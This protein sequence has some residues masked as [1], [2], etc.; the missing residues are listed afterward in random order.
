MRDFSKYDSAFCANIPIHII[1]AVQ[2]YGVLLVVDKKNGDIVQLSENADQLFLMPARKMA[3]RLFS[4]F[5]SLA[6]VPANWISE[7]GRYNIVLDIGAQEHDAILHVD[8][9]QLTI[10]IELASI[11]P[12][13]QNAIDFFREIKAPMEQIEKAETL[14]ALCTIAADVLKR[15]S[16][17]DKVMIYSFD[18]DWNGFVLAEAREPDMESYLGFTFPAADIPKPARDLYLRNAYRCIPDREAPSV[19]LYP[20]VHPLTETFLDM[21]LC[22]LRAVPTV[23]LEYLKNM[24]VGASMSVRLLRHGELWG[25]IACHHKTA[26]ASNG[27]QKALFELFSGVIS[28]RITELENQQLH[29][30]HSRLASLYA[31]LIDGVNQ[32]TSM[33]DALLYG[34]PNVLELFNADGA[35]AVHHQQS[36]SV[37]TAPE[38]ELLKDLLLW[39]HVKQLRKIYQTDVLPSVYEMNEDQ[40][41]LISGLLAIPIR[42]SEDEYLLLFR[43]EVKRTTNW[44][45]NPA[46]RIFFEKDPQQF[47]PRHSFQL[48]QE[49]VSGSS[50]A[51]TYE[52]QQLAEKLRLFILQQAM[53]G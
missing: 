7:T 29:Q 33:M 38:A 11:A 45:G 15:L 47:H 23:H 44:G 37:G 46:E 16:G 13:Q 27:R 41:P 12:N 48:W 9:K 28:A 43:K 49:H 14:P 2:S 42:A 1:N 3:G 30:Q 25:L 26:Y 32:S 51:W 17:F 36:K 53:K 5:V 20:I 24:R 6:H 40:K 52:E 19:P 22:N 35:I 10:E 18:E 34:K 8:E 4:E 21:S 39:L 50:P 31:A